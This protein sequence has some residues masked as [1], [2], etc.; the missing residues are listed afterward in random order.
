MKA[1]PKNIFLII[2]ILLVFGVLMVMESLKNESREK[3]WQVTHSKADKK[4]YGLYVLFYRLQDLF[5]QK[6]IKASNQTIY[7][8]IEY[9]EQKYSDKNFDFNYVFINHVF[10]PIGED[11]NSLFEFVEYGGN[12]FVAAER[13]SDDFMDSLNFEVNKYSLINENDSTGVGFTNQNL[14]SSACFFPTN[15]VPLYFDKYDKQNTTVLAQTMDKKPVFLKIKYGN[16]YFYLNSTP[17]IFTNYHILWSKNQDFMATA[18]SYL[19]IKNVYWDEYYKVGRGEVMSPMR[20]I[21]SRPPLRNA[22]YLVLAA[23]LLWT[24][25]QS[26]RQQKAI[27]VIAPPRND[28]MDFARVI[29]MLHFQHKDHLNVAHKKI[30][31]FLE[32][33]RS[34]HF[35]PTHEFKQDFYEKLAAKTGREVAEV[36]TLFKMI[37]AIHQHQAITEEDLLTLNT[38]IELFKNSQTSV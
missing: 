6:D 15:A 27:P 12:V 36:V 7:E 14:R 19:P 20:F 9:S 30:N 11:M 26:R 21:L 29:G 18:L 8:V 13:F 34:H 25:F 22:L 1:K 5:P 17:L 35:L 10:Q 2:F 38:Q 28:T 23:L 33:I 24:I 37:Q 4:P 31:H 3:K 16:G 32:Y